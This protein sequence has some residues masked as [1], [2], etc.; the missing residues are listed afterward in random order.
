MATT[1]PDVWNVVGDQSAEE[2]DPAG[3]STRRGLLGSAA[4]GFAL[5]ASGLFLPST[6]ED[7]AARAG[8][9]GRKHRRTHGDDKKENRRQRQKREG[10][11]SRPLFRDTS[12]S[13]DIMD[14]RTQHF[15]F[16][17]T[18]YYRVLSGGLDDYNGPWIDSGTS[19]QGEG[20]TLK[21]RYAPER[22]RVGVLLRA[23]DGGYRAPDLFVDVRNIAFA[24]PRVAAY[25]G[26][27]LD[28]ASG[29]LGEAVL[30]ER[31]MELVWIPFQGTKS[32]NFGLEYELR[33]SPRDLCTGSLYRHLDSDD[34]IEFE[35]RMVV[36]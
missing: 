3:L 12:L 18:F 5:A 14:G 15:T 25:S 8:K 21:H 16:S 29:K 24:A 4:G 17:A 1:P 30:T 32:R 9:R 10:R 6:S 26:V 19:V 34:F 11:S 36:L 28:P 2:P 33:N 20:R 35:L 13:L 22:F 23:F 31:T 27:N 7:V